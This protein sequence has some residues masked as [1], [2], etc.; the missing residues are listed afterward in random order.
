[1]LHNVKEFTFFVYN[2]TEFHFTAAIGMT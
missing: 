1:M 2:I